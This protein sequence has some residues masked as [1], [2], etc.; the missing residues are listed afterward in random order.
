MALK[1]APDLCILSMFFMVCRHLPIQ[2][3]VASLGS[4][5]HTLGHRNVTIELKT[6]WL[7][8]AGLLVSTQ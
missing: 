6:R 3:K 1:R 7:T 2:S 5:L 8:P 4:R